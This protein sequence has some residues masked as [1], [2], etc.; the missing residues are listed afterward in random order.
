MWSVIVPA[1]ALLV[2]LLIGG[3]V[4]GVADGDGDS[5]S[6]APEPTES[7]TDS[8]SPSP[9]DGGATALVVPDE[10][11]AAA[12]TVEEVTALVRQGVGAI[13]D[14][15]TAEL[16]SVLRELEGLDQQAREQAQACRE[17]RIEESPTE[18]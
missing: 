18:G 6:A 12:D 8:P 5:P 16:R 11:L 10:C 1:V 17:S 14:L 4:V 3:V 13:R 2:G 7:P 9:A 15:Q